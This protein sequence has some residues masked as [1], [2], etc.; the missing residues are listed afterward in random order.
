METTKIIKPT[1]VRSGEYTLG[2]FLIEY[3]PDMEIAFL[4]GDRK[5]WQIMVLPQSGTKATEGAYGRFETLRE[6]VEEITT[7]HGWLL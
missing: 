6:A 1:K 7:Q 2:P 3:D 4:K 5:F